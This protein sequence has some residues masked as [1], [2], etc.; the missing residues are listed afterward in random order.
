MDGIG[1]GVVL[2]AL[3]VLVVAAIVAIRGRDPAMAV[4]AVMLGFMPAA[5]VGALLGAAATRIRRH[6]VVAL[7]A[8]ALAAV[9]TLGRILD[10]AG[11]IVP[12]CVPTLVLVAIL[13]RWTRVS[14]DV[15]SGGSAMGG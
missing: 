15:A 11:L 8:P 7:A 10:V 5:L 3:D 1:K 9:A 13:E 12:A 6:R 2:A 4:F 14:P